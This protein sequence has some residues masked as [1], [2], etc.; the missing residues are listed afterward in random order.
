MI[1]MPAVMARRGQTLPSRQKMRRL[2]VHP[3]RGTGNGYSSLKQARH[4][5]RCGSSRARRSPGRRGGW[6][7]APT[8]TLRYPPVRL[9][10]FGKTGP[11]RIRGASVDEPSRDGP[12][13]RIQHGPR[14]PDA[15]AMVM[16]RDVV[17]APASPP[18]T[19]IR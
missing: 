9:A 2:V 12:C 1:R 8:H 16:P 13:K 19:V 4:R 5:R 14:R 15:A 18:E 11:E 3:S 17:T 10:V 7:N 6:G